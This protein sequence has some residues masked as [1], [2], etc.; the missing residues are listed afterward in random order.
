MHTRLPIGLDGI[1]RHIR[2]AS[3]VVEHPDRPARAE[4]VARIAAAAGPGVT[5]SAAFHR[6]PAYRRQLGELLDIAGRGR[7]AL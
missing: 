6:D 7:A 1:A 4:R 2:A 3:H 5:P